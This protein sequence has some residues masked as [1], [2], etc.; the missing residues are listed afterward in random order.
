[1]TAQPSEL[2]NWGQ[3]IPPSLIPKSAPL[4][5]QHSNVKYC[6]PEECSRTKMQPQK[7]KE[8]DEWYPAAVP[9]FIVRWVSVTLAERGKVKV[10]CNVSF[11]PKVL[12]ELENNTAAD[13]RE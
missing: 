2:A 8:G 10:H 11:L 4:F 12:E 6:A 13:K 1:M 7:M 3:A 5:A 9:S